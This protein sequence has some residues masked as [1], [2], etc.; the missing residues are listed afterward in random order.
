[1]MVAH[2]FGFWPFFRVTDVTHVTRKW[3]LVKKVGHPP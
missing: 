1:M 2:F 3:A